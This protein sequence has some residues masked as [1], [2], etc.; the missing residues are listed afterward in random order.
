[1]ARYHEHYCIGTAADRFLHVDCDSEQPFLIVFESRDVAYRYRDKFAAGLKVFT[2]FPAD[3]FREGV[4]EYDDCVRLCVDVRDRRDLYLELTWEEFLDRQ[5]YAREG[6]GGMRRGVIYR[7]SSSEKAAR[8]DALEAAAID[9]ADLV[10][11]N[12]CNE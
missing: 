8:D 11:M 2:V 12:K 6:L 7:R 4:D 3:L 10:W 5:Q 1:M 9:A